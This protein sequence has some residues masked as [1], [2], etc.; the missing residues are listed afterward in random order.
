MKVVAFNGS[1]NKEGNTYHAI[2]IVADELEKEGIITEIIHVGNK[3]I[4]GCTACNQCVKNKNEKCV[5]PSDEVNEWIQNMK[6]AEG[7]ILGSP[8]HYSAIG[9]TMKS[10]LDRAFYVAGVNN[11]ILR[12]KVAASVVAVRRSGGL[13]TF[14]QLNNYINYSEMLIPTS[15]YWNVIH[16]AKPGEVMQDEEGVQIMRILG[17]NMAWL[18]KLVENGKGSI[19]EPERERKSL[20]NFIR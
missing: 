10:F 8:V 5:L 20:T 14:D 18:M 6:G 13:P 3:S 17:K 12:H 9:G 4:R 19:K 15:N 16:G 11:G 7:L 1:P 2:K